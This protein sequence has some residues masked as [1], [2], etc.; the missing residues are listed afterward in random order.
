[1][2]DKYPEHDVPQNNIVQRFFGQRWSAIV[3]EILMTIV[4][5]VAAGR[6]FDF[7][8]PLE[9]SADTAAIELLAELPPEVAE[10]GERISIDAV[11][12]M[13]KSYLDNGDFAEAKALLDLLIAAEPDNVTLTTSDR[14]K[15][16][17]AMRRLPIW[18]IETRIW[19]CG[20][21]PYVR[22]GYRNNN[23]CYFAGELGEYELALAHCDAVLEGAADASLK[24]SALENRCWVRVEM[25]DYGSGIDDCLAVLQED[26]DCQFVTCVL[27]H[28]NLGRIRIAQG[29]IAVAVSHFDIASSRGPSFEYQYANM[30]LEL[31]RVYDRLGRSVKALENY[32]QYLQVVGRNADPVAQSR[33]SALRGA[34]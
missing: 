14:A 19:R 4:I 32:Q 7:F 27:A 20:W 12:H 28:Y 25:G 2:Y 15:T 24:L 3:I 9:P 16:A 10:P 26:P 22:Q 31:A 5:T 13:A 17:S 8:G 21:S 29:K 1:M 11:R 33:L 23:L 6:A 18:H 34:D 30:Y